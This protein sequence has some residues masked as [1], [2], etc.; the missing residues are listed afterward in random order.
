MGKT[1]KYHLRPGY[2]SD[3]LLLQFFIDD[4][5][6]SFNNDLLATLQAINPKIDSIEDF[7]MN[8]EIVFCISSSCMNFYLSKDIWGFAFIMAENNQLAI[9]IIDEILSRSDLFEKEEVDFDDY[10]DVRS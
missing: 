9:K 6:V 2:G 4:N 5:D 1:Y 8:D 7:W 10:K 3:K